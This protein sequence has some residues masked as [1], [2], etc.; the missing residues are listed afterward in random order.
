MNSQEDTI[1]CTNWPPRR[2]KKPTI[3]LGV[4]ADPRQCLGM[5]WQCLGTKGDFKV[6]TGWTGALESANRRRQFVL[7]VHGLDTKAVVVACIC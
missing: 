4:H 2:L 3:C 5:S 6:S 1:A 7:P